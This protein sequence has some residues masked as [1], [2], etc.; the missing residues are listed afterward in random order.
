MS[1]DTPDN[2]AQPSQQD[3]SQPAGRLR[4]LSNGAVLGANGKFVANP[5]GGTTAFTSHT[6]REYVTRR[7]ELR[8]QAQ[9]ASQ[10][11]IG[12][13]VPTGLA[14]DAWGR[15]VGAQYDLAMDTD[16]NVS[17]KAFENVG[18]ATGFLVDERHTSHDVNVSHNLPDFSAVRRLLAAVS[19][20]LEGEGQAVDVEWTDLE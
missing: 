2:T 9:L 12:K 14:L 7:E 6:A 3:T 8:A 13:R 20:E 15:A 10:L 11:E 18:R 5:G 16:R 4:T 1:D 17:V 19:G